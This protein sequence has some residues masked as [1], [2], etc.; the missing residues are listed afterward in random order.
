MIMFHEFHDI[1]KAACSF[2]SFALSRKIKI[3]G[4]K[5][6]FDR[7]KS[8]RIDKVVMYNVRLTSR[9]GLL[10]CLTHTKSGQLL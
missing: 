10:R 7:C 8:H 5:R 4:I 9:V 3:H 2:L 6:R 1:W